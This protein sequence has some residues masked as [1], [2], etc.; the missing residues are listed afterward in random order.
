VNRKVGKKSD[1]GVASSGQ[2]AVVEEV[3][4][5]IYSIKFILQSLGYQVSSFSSGVPFQASL[6]EFSPD[7]VIVDMMIPGRQGYEIIESIRESSLKKVPVLAITAA[8]MEGDEKDVYEAGGQDI[9]PKP[10]TVTELQKK[11]EKWLVAEG[12]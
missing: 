6:I 12:G 4:D 10:Y 5:N 11:L 7:L 9:L 3:A 8:A 1:K 2:I